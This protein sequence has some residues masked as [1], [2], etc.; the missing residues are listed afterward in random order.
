MDVIVAILQ[1]LWLIIPA[2][3]ANSAAVLFGGGKPIDGGAVHKD[4]RRV[5]GD[6]KTWRGFIG[7]T[8]FGIFIGLLMSV[9]N[10]FSEWPEITF[11]S[12][13]SSIVVIC[14]LS[15]GALLGDLIGS[16]FKRRMGIERG[17]KTPVLDQ[18]DFLIFAMLL[19]AILQWPWFFEHYINGYAIL[20]LVAVIVITPVLH[21]ITNI[22]G[23]R[24]G[25]KEVPW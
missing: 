15:F 17:K 11:G 25:K 3:V 19:V 6:G 13:P 22:I 12:F 5:L 10:S 20:G 4:G 7:G 8:A 9:A 18:Y 1:G 23:H 2:F 21:R 24:I 14:S 16:F